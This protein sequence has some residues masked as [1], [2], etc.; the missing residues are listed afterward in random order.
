MSVVTCGV[1]RREARYAALVVPQGG[2]G[3]RQRIKIILAGGLLALTLFAAAA[4]DTFEDGMAAARRGD[5]AAAIRL[6]RP[7]AEQGNANAQGS[8]GYMY[9]KGHGVLQNYARAFMWYRKAVDQ[10]N[11]QAQLNL[12]SMYENGVGV[13]QDYARAVVLYRKAADQGLAGA[14]F[15]LSLMYSKGLGVPQDYAQAA[16][17]YDR[18]K[19]ASFEIPSSTT[20]NGSS[21][22]PLE[23]QGGTFVLPVLINNAITLSFVVDSGAA[24]VSIPRDVFSTLI[25]SGTISEAD[26]IGQQNYRLADGS[27][28]VG[29]TFRIR[30]LK[31]GNRELENVT[32]SVAPET[33]TL[34]L[35]QSFLSRFNS[36]S[37][38]NNR[39]VLLLN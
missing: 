16:M 30:V 18:S 15:F 33:G 19:N 21:E 24:D 35:G 36:W 17:W 2:R 12:G 1:K 25:R 28:S 5:Y 23:E 32:G 4:A 14:M 26:V 7:L 6:W 29:I 11:A 22:I 3:A 38:D 8:L 13:P 37:I 9:E 10:G 39:H 20:T 31:V 27:T 34:L